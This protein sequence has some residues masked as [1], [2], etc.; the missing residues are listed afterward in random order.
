M[1]IYA[2]PLTPH[3][4]RLTPHLLGSAKWLEIGRVKSNSR[5]QVSG[6]QDLYWAIGP[7]F[8]CGV[9]GVSWERKL[10]FLCLFHTVDNGMDVDRL[11]TRKG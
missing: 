8:W 4:S 6:N 9:S 10:P 5:I 2:S 3:A 11:K 7:V 1:K